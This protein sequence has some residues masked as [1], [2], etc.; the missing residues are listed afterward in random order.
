MQ[1]QENQDKNE[2]KDIK[3]RQKCNKINKMKW[4]RTKKT[5]ENDMKPKETRANK[6]IAADESLQL[7][8]IEDM[9]NGE[10]V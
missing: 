5:L 6:A 9:C 3:K 7:F 10:M 2:T 4:A 1:Q 8:T